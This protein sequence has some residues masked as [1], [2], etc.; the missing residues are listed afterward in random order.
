MLLLIFSWERGLTMTNRTASPKEPKLDLQL[1]SEGIAKVRAGFLIT[2][3][4]LLERQERFYNMPTSSGSDLIMKTLGAGSNIAALPDST[5]RVSNSQ[6]ITV[7]ES[8]K[9]R[10]IVSKGNNT[11]TIIEIGD[12]EK[13]IGSNKAAKKMFAFALIKMNEQAFDY[14]SGSLY[15]DEI[16]FSLQ[17]LVDIGY[18]SSIRAARRGFLTAMDTLTDL[19][20]KAVVKRGKKVTTTAPED[21]DGAGILVMFT[22]ATVENNFCKVLL[23]YKVNW[24]P[25]FQYFTVLPKFAFQL[26]NKPFDLLY[27]IFYLA[28]QNNKQIKD[29]GYFDIGFR[30][31]QQRLELP[32]EADTKEPTKHIRQPIEDAVAAIEEQLAAAGTA[33]ELTI[34]PVFDVRGN[35]REYLDNGYLRIS[36]KGMYAEPFI[37]GSTKQQKAIEKCQKRQEAIV[38][39]AIAAKIAKKAE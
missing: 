19:K 15:H 39:K 37:E 7:R 30:T 9:K 4:S 31:I 14:K 1:F 36:L 24:A 22:G 28:R 25:L 5:K 32:N 3:E 33:Q 6:I 12:I 21:A 20:L 26:G 10:Q 8:G 18:Y 38:D 13:L 27:T 2:P 35:I 17:E 23:N 29:K 34:T 16:G 11:E